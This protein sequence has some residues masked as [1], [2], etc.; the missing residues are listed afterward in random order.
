VVW[1][2][3]AGTIWFVNTS[4]KACEA[5]LRQFEDTFDT[6]LIPQT[7]RHVALRALSGDSNHV[8]RAAVTTF[9]KEEPK[10]RLVAAG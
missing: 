3:A 4:D 9:S 5:F 6:T 7:P 1:N 10:Y 8:D 2:I